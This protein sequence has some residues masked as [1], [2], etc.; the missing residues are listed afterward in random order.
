M[1]SSLLRLENDLR[2]YACLSIFLVLHEPTIKWKVCHPLLTSMET[3]L[4]FHTI[5][6]NGDHDCL[7]IFKLN[8][9]WHF[10]Q[11]IIW[12]WK[13]GIILGWAILLTFIPYNN[14]RSIKNYFFI[15]NFN[16][17]FFHT[18]V[19]YLS[20]LFPSVVCPIW[21]QWNWHTYFF[22]NLLTKKYAALQLWMTKMTVCNFGRTPSQGTGKQAM[23]TPK[24]R[25][26]VP[27]ERIL[28]VSAFPLKKLQ[29][30]CF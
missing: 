16:C 26:A 1:N 2:V 14:S 27:I 23:I 20:D 12:L 29:D 3:W 15:V 21:W 10:I 7:L 18:V 11:A 6:V 17:K 19:I 5:K 25:W 9:D 8:N 30:C 22:L 24:V 13:T 28:P 4:Y